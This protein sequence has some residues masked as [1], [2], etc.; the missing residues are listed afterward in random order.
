MFESACGPVQVDQA[1]AAKLTQ[2]VDFHDNFRKFQF[3]FRLN[4]A[5]L[6][7]TVP[8]KLKSAQNSSE[9]LPVWCVHG[10]LA[11]VARSIALSQS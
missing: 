5:V 1:Q 10:S 7:A 8:A 11:S 9:K 3:V 4:G 6:I 2:V